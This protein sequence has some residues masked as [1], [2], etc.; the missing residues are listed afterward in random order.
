[1]LVRERARTLILFRSGGWVGGWVGAGGKI[2]GRIR[3]SSAKVLV[4]VEAQLGNVFNNKKK[5]EM[6]PLKMQVILYENK[7]DLIKH[8]N[9][10]K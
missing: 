9:T 7:S 3:L 8:F 2:N 6:N 5:L 1:M 4:E 10:I